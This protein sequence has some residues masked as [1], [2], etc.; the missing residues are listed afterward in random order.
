LLGLQTGEPITHD[1]LRRAYLRRLRAH[2]PERDP[3]GFRQL[4]EAFEAL[5]PLARMHDYVRAAAAERA[6]SGAAAD[7][8]EPER[9]EASPDDDEDEASG[10]AGPILVQVA[11]GELVELRPAP[12]TRPPGWT[13]PVSAHADAP[14]RAAGTSSTA[15]SATADVERPGDA[16]GRRGAPTGKSSDAAGASRAGEVHDR[17]DRRSPDA[18]ES[19]DADESSD[20]DEP[21]DADESSDAD[22]LPDD[23]PYRRS[24]RPI[25]E[26]IMDPPTTL[27]EVTD[28]ILALLQA[29]RLDAALDIAE[30][31]SRSTLDDH[32]EVSP[33][34]AQCWALT[35][36]LLDVAP[37]VPESLRRA[38][39]RGIAAG[40]LTMACPA[41]EGLQA[42]HPAQA[43]DLARH[44][45]KRA[46]SLHK[47]L[48]QPLQGAPVLGETLERSTRSSRAP[49]WIA[50][51]ILS[52][53]VRAAGSCEEHSRTPSFDY[54]PRPQV[55]IEYM[56]RPPSQF[57]SRPL[58]DDR[59]PVRF[60]PQHKSWLD[61]R[62]EAPT[63]DLPGVPLGGASGAKPQ[64]EVR[65]EG[66]T[67]PRP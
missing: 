47:V 56:P 12:R 30:R 57:D 23:S 44:L 38:I 15:G 4:R 10:P 42:R 18:D 29:G 49:I 40:D 14:D 27:R 34:D 17:A 33:N 59:A 65:P 20:A 19:F 61:R 41:A 45:A 55:P 53:L 16:A 8:D 51:L 64:L 5:E 36:E 9:S 3:E 1:R 35:R 50:V 11:N 37:A 54:S 2:P 63:R 26:R 43:N 32:R 21:F 67:P 7:A 39:A 13:R 25:D 46:T 60:D 22:Q 28:E 6:Q 31:W 24:G 48:G 58:L 52:A 66:Q 62:L